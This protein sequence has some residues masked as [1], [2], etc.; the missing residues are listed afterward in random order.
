MALAEKG[1]V[2]FQRIQRFPHAHLP[3]VRQ[4]HRPLRRTVPKGIELRVHPQL[5]ILLHKFQAAGQI[6]GQDRRPQ[7]QMPGMPVED[8][9]FLRVV[10]HL[11]Q[12][13]AQGDGGSFQQHLPLLGGGGN[14]DGE[15]VLRPV[16]PHGLH[17]HQLVDLPMVAEMLL[18]R[19]AGQEQ[20]HRQQPYK[21]LSHL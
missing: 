11:L 19:A 7:E 15:E 6:V 21:E 1:H 2:L 3:A 13:P 17:Q 4:R 20:R 9:L 18:P 16:H 5:P 10:L 12:S 14:G 8:I